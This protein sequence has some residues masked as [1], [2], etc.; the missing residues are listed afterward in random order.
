[1]SKQNGKIPSET[2]SQTEE[3]LRNENDSPKQPPSQDTSDTPHQNTEQAPSEDKTPEKIK[4]SK[5]YEKIL[6]D[7]YLPGVIFF[8]FM[9]MG[10]HISQVIYGFAH[11]INYYHFVLNP[12]LKFTVDFIGGERNAYSV[13]I[14]ASVWTF[15][16]VSC[17]IAYTALKAMLRGK[18]RFFKYTAIWFGTFGFAWGVSVA[19]ILSLSVIS[20]NIGTTKITLADAPID[21]LLAIAFIIGFYNEQA[22]KLLER[23]R[24][25]FTGSMEGEKSSK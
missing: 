1:M 16:G 10:L 24:D 20:I 3:S 8:I 19:L 25:K 9:G 2:K 23:V 17:R 22:L 13:G 6:K 7:E 11:G 12:N 4:K 14:E 21:T 15:W 5:F 18:F